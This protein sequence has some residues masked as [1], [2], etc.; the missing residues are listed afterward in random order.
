MVL[1]HAGDGVHAVTGQDPRPVTSPLLT[2]R[3]LGGILEL[4]LD[5][6]T[7]IGLE[8]RDDELRAE[9]ARRLGVPDGPRLTPGRVQAEAYLASWRRR[10]A[11]TEP[12]EAAA[13]AAEPPRLGLS[14][15]PYSHTY[16]DPRTGCHVP[17]TAARVVEGTRFLSTFPGD[18]LTSSVPGHPVDVPAPLQPVFQYKTGAQ[19][20]PQG[21]GYGWLG[22]P[23]GAEYVLRMAEE[24]GRSITSTVIYVDS[25]LRLGGHEL[26]TAYELRHR[27]QAVHIGNMGSCG[28]TLPLHPRTALALSWAEAIL[29]G[30][31][32]ELLTGLPTYWGG[33]IEPFDLRAQ[34][35][36]FGA[37]EQALY[38]RL[39]REA[40]TWLSGGR[41]RGGHAP[42]LT[43]AKT[44]GAQAA[45]E[46]GLS[47]ALGVAWG[48]TSL[49]AAGSLSADEVFS[50]VQVILDLELRDWLERFSAGV[51]PPEDE[52]RD[53]L[54]TIREALAGRGF[55]AT[56]ATLDHYAA[57]SWFPR[58]LRREMLDRW[59]DL[60]SPSAEQTAREE[61][62]E[63]IAGAQWTLPE[64]LFGALE[65][66]Y[67]E[68]AARLG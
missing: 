13:T 50:P 62:L 28:A 34:T 36:P 38:Y 17:L 33:T 68:A 58:H 37:P 35:I 11:G 66:I 2:D 29:A 24:Q 45:L 56:D 57:L 64:P 51:C 47:A 6:V 52:P 55:V 59:R 31:C 65:A 16:L 14:V 42:L 54:R 18:Q 3:E 30:L 7:Q 67:A 63:R 61:A 4:A 48:C 9:A 22:P 1:G 26:R 25:P 12:P 39:G 60:G 49:G 23:R 15:M 20:N 46:K 19:Y 40:S 10:V 41:R 44:P 53:P 21:G 27:F 8:I 32:V 43:M 5:I